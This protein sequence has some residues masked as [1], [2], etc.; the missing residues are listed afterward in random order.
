MEEV[1]N[2]NTFVQY[3]TYYIKLTIYINKG[4]D[5]E[6]LLERLIKLYNKYKTIEAAGDKIT[7]TDEAYLR[8]C[9]KRV[10]LVLKIDENNQPVDI[11]NK[12]NQRKMVNL[13]GHPSLAN[14]DFE[15]MV[16]HATQHNLAILTEIPLLFSLRESKY[17]QLL[18]QYTRALYYISQIL[19]SKTIETDTQNETYFFKKELSKSAAVKLEEILV[20]ISDT[21]EKIKIGQILSIDKF[22]NTKLI[23]TGINEKNVN[24]A[25]NEVKEIFMKKG[26]GKDK[27]M[28]RMIDSISEK[29]TSVDLSKGNILQNMF[30][31]AQNVANELK[32]DLENNPDS[33]QNTLGA[34]TEVFKEAM[35]D[36]SNGAEVPAELKN[37]FEK[38]LPAV[39]NKS[40]MPEDEI[41]NSL[42][43]IVN[44][45]G[46]DKTE[47]YGSIKNDQGE[48]DANKLQNTLS[49]LQKK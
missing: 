46:M 28:N 3:L 31:I 41:L 17:K 4:T 45:Y 29:L 16:K 33:L 48:I 42:D 22:L 49:K 19:I 2:T 35:N 21:E 7:E 8:R 18:W 30:G 14:D 39:V 11:T 1:I 43:G 32:N 15:G 12:E 10:N 36:S 38:I 25:K 13:S 47:F 5:K 44:A 6:N 26:I 27:S 37:I 9:F 20:T 24:D 34:I 40:E 23:K